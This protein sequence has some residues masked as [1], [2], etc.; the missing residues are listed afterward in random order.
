MAPDNPHDL[1]GKELG[2]CRIEALLGAGGMGLVYRGTHLRLNKP[3]A[4]KVILPSIQR[5]TAAEE[6][7]L[8]EARL[9]ASLEDPHII[10]VYDVG[11][12]GHLSYIVMQ[13]VHARVGLA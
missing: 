4:V 5:S 13:L 10:R 8:N 12:E 6:Q 11:R 9:A 2:P 7:L 1:I 3:V